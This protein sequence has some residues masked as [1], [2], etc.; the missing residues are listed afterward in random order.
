MCGF[1]LGVGFLNLFQVPSKYILT[2]FSRLL[3][4]LSRM[5]LRVLGIT[6]WPTKAVNISL[7]NGTAEDSCRKAE[8]SEMVGVSLG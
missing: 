4:Q 8:G 5:V 6:E 1:A 3:S 2:A 7:S